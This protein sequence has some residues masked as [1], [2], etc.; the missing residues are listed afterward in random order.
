MSA[1]ITRAKAMA[2]AR[3]PQAAEAGEL[4]DLF[5]RSARRK[6]GRLFHDLW[7]NDDVARYKTALHV[8]AGR[9]LFVEAGI[10]G[11]DSPEKAPA[12]SQPRDEARAAVAK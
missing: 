5:C 7:S 12:L 3:H 4:A 10:V 6:I 9:H 8:L 2:D 11:L 1:T